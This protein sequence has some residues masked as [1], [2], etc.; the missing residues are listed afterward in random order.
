[1]DPPMKSFNPNK[2]LKEDFVSNL[3]G[4][5]MVELFMLLTMIPVLV[6]VRHS[7]SFNG[8]IEADKK[9]TSSKKSDDGVVSLQSWK[10]YT[11]TIAFDFLTLLLPI[12]V[13]LI[14]LAEWT[15]VR[16]VILTLVLIF[17]VI[18]KRFGFSVEEESYLARTYISSYRVLM[19]VWCRCLLHACAF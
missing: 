16:S 10:T 17:S 18:F 11:L 2:I 6:V 4:S 14:V 15:Y 1:M 19:D 7:F 13:F 5:S 3:T 9:M 8:R 12:F